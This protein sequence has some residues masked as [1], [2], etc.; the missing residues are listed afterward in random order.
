LYREPPPPIR[1]AVGSGGKNEAR[2]VQ[3]IQRTL[4]ALGYLPEDPFDS[5][6]G[7]MDA[8]TQ[9]AIHAAQQ[10]AGLRVDGLVSPGG[11]TER[12]L[13]GQISDLG[14]RHAAD[15]KRYSDE[16]EA[17]PL[18][19]HGPTGDRGMEQRSGAPSPEDENGQIVEAQA[20]LMPPAYE[21]FPDPRLPRRGRPRLGSEGL[22]EPI[23]ENM[24]PRYPDLR[25]RVRMPRDQVWANPGEPRRPPPPARRFI[26]PP[27]FGGPPPRA[28]DIERALRAPRIPD[29]DTTETY[30][31]KPGS[32]LAI[33]IVGSH[34]YGRPGKPETQQATEA[35]VEKLKK[36]CQK[37]LDKATFSEH[38]FERYF[39]PFNGPE[40]STRGSSYADSWFQI[41]YKGIDIDMIGDTYSTKADQEPTSAEELR[42]MR[43]DRNLSDRN[44]IVVRMPKPW[45]LGQQIDGAA[46]TEA[47]KR[48]C[49]EVKDAVDRGEI[50]PGKDNAQWQRF[51]KGLTKPRGTRGSFRITPRG[52]VNDR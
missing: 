3:S 4:G 28:G 31:P 36:Q 17:T 18:A 48:L 37:V 52:P 2:D 51:F 13:N 27:R 42:Y 8:S 41:K 35:L 29:F 12:A 11:E 16:V 33:P 14:R 47:A 7:V 39:R 38:K 26:Q 10:D 49:K 44:R 40:G 1:A 45:M 15:W 19:W 21:P 46:L 24:P 25:R 23:P 22:F 6:H 5:P 34:T 9:E 20:R 30:L 32:P 43:L 50:G